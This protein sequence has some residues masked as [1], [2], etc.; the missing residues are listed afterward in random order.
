MRTTRSISLCAVTL[1]LL[2]L[3]IT[4]AA[5]T[6]GLQFVSLPPCRVVDTRNATGPFGGP[7]LQALTPR[8][9]ALPQGACPN[10]PANVSAYSLN[11]TVVPHNG[12]LGYLTV[13]PTGQVQ[14]GVSTLNSLDGRIK[15]NA[16]IVQAG[17]N[18]SI[19]AFATDTT[20]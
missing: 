4:L 1:F 5:Q 18:G 13:W 11:V 14:A 15:A 2:P 20:D 3:P 12:H 10:I 17:T 6:S 9:F 19:S 7:S 16:S 8:D